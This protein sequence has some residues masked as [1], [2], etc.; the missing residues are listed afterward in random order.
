[1]LYLENEYVLKNHFKISN[2]S[3]DFSSLS[4]LKKNIY[5]NNYSKKRRHDLLPAAWGYD[6]LYSENNRPFSIITK[7][8]NL[9]IKVYNIRVVRLFVPRFYYDRRNTNFLKNLKFVGVKKEI[10][11]K[12]FNSF[13]ALGRKLNEF[14]KKDKCFELS[15]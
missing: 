5:L 14:Q 7:D 11:K 13:S 3:F 6:I 2:N 9:S 1:M 8:S 12:H 15:C 10:D 4:I